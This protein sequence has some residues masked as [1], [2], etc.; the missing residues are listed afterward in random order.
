MQNE[1]SVTFGMLK[2]LWGNMPALDIMN[3][4]QNE[5]RNYDKDIGL[6]FAGESDVS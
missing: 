2:Y 3:I 4:D 1:E 6:C 5:G